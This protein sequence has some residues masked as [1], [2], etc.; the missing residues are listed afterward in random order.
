MLD[1]LFRFLISAWFALSVKGI[2]CK[3]T[4]H[5]D[6]TWLCMVNLAAK[7]QMVE[8]ADLRKHATS[9]VICSASFAGC[10]PRH[11]L[12]LALGSPKSKV[13]AKILQNVSEF[14]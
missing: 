9:V 10:T 4:N 2:N 14:S 7:P 13:Q 5:T 11:T 8:L 12:L 1:A 6:I 3:L